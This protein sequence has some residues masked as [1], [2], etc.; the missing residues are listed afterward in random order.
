M[1]SWMQVLFHTQKGSRI[2]KYSPS[3]AEG[4]QLHNLLFN[5]GEWQNSYE[6]FLSTYELYFYFK[7]S[8]FA[9]PGLFTGEN[10]TI[11]YLQTSIMKH[12]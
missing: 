1:H 9:F 12:L 11:D 8:K 4:L 3:P 5:P 6:T 2:E 10:N 7:A